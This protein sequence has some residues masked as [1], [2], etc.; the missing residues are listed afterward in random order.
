MVP[1]LLVNG[2]YCVYIIG[3]CLSLPV[4][5][6]QISLY[7]GTV[8]LPEFPSP[9]P[10]PAISEIHNLPYSPIFAIKLHITKTQILTLHLPYNYLNLPS[11]PISYLSYT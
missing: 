6:K 8:F 1:C 4:L 10:L 5:L 7:Q 2:C 11:P 3:T 9:F